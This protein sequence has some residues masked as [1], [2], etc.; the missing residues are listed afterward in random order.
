MIDIIKERLRLYA[1]D[2]E[3]AED[4]ALKEIIQEIALF[5]LWQADFFDT[6]AF[7]GGTSL[8]I[9]HKLPRFSEDLDFILKE[10]NEEFDWSRYLDSMLQ[11][12]VNFGIQAE[13]SDKGRMGQG[14]RKAIIKDN[15]LSN[16]LD[17]SFF[18]GPV[19]KKLRIKLEVD[20]NP[21]AYSAFT[22]T[23]LNFP[24]DFEVCHQDLTS[25]FALKIHAL[26]CRPYVK[27]RDWFDFNWYIRQGIKPNLRHL[28]SALMQFGPWQDQ[29]LQI[30]WEWVNESLKTRIE[31]IDWDDAVTDVENFLD[32]N[33]RQGLAL[34]SSRFFL[35]KLAA[36]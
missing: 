7:Q 15:S 14:V 35:S 33:E 9:L 22:Y 18:R 24:S 26:L 5:G 2:S 19:D 17:L 28:E 36:I 10:S 34:W 1:A 27:G 25:N 20:I 29:Q 31:Q 3:I 30:N 21:P 11:T 23:Y 13:V 4:H 12:L 6:A 8:R 32:E 16:Q